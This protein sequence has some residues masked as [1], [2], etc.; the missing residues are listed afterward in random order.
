MS[1]QL[2]I[3]HPIYD[4]L[5]LEASAY[6]YGYL[7]SRGYID[8]A[9]DEYTLGLRHDLSEIAKRSTLKYRSEGL[10]QYVREFTGAELVYDTVAPS[11]EAP[12][13]VVIIP[14][15]A[16]MIVPFLRGAFDACAKRTD[17]GVVFRIGILTPNVHNRVLEYIK[18]LGIPFTLVRRDLHYDGIA[19]YELMY[20]LSDSNLVSKNIISYY[21]DFA[22]TYG[23]IESNAKFV[24][25]LEDAPAPS[26]KSPAD[27]GWDLHLVAALKTVGDVTVFRT[28]IAVAPPPGYYFE[29]VPRSSLGT[30]GWSLANSV[31]VIDAG[32]RG[33]I[34]VALRNHSANLPALPWRAVQIILR[35]SFVVE[36][37]EVTVLDP[38]PRGDNGGLGSANFVTKP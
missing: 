25:V 15:S 23:A 2:A 26:R 34:L 33:E 19:A 11:R 38:T 8:R 6:I 27:A 31:G 28:G 20:R 21:H 29:L 36:F 22:D 18:P 14:S 3:V 37:D 30:S 9:G 17:T 35:K 12:K 1:S 7:S 5:A 4:T 13:N 16:S 24:R 32:Y 10:I